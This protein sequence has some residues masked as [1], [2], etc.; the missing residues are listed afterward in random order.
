MLYGAL[1]TEVMET[2]WEINRVLHAM[3][4]MFDKSPARRDVYVRETG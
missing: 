4:K 1:Q 3:W 2:D